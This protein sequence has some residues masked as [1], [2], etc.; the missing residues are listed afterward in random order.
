[1]S[2]K[3]NIV[4]MRDGDDEEDQGPAPAR[5]RRQSVVV[6]NYVNVMAIMYM[7]YVLLCI[8]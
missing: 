5:F 4:E 7:Y 8:M 1:M 2:E 6:K 3:F